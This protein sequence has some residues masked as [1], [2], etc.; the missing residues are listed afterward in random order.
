M[1]VRM[2]HVGPGRS[3]GRLQTDAGRRPAG[4]I[5]LLAP[6]A[7]PMIRAVPPRA[8]GAERAERLADRERTD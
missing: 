6:G 5:V 2:N 1:S 3:V 8:A 4:E 7:A